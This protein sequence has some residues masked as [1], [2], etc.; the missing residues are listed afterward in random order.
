MKKSILTLLAVSF[1]SALSFAQT[2]PTATS[3]KHTKKHAKSVSTAANYH[4]P[5]KCENDK[6]YSQAGKCSK[7]GMDLVK[8]SN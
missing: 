5:M 4:C 7:C 3:K 6:K 2:A 1:I 8:I